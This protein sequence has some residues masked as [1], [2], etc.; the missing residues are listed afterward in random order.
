MLQNY[1]QTAGVKKIKPISLFWAVQW[2]KNQVITSLFKLDFWNF[3]VSYDKND[4][5]ES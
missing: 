2:P 4:F 1:V 3:Y 5:L